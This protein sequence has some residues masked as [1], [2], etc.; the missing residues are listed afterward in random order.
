MGRMDTRPGIWHTFPECVAEEESSF[1]TRGTLG[2][3]KKLC[4]PL[5]AVH[6]SPRPLPPHTRSLAIWLNSPPFAPPAQSG[7]GGV[8]RRRVAPLLA[9]EPPPRTQAAGGGAAGAGRGR[10]ALILKGPEGRG[11]GASFPDSY[12]LKAND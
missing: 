11:G 5:P 3:L 8:C 2:A 6:S 10:A 12:L 7:A 4:F 1:M 9:Q